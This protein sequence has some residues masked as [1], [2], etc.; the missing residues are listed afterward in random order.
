MLKSLTSPFLALRSLG[1]GRAA[2]ARLSQVVTA[3]AAVALVSQDKLNPYVEARREWNERYSDYIKQAHHWRI[4]ALICAVTA[5]ISVGGVAYIGAQSK[6]VPYV[7]EVD[8]LGAAA[9]VTPADRTTTVDPRVIKAYLARF[10]ADWRAVTVDTQAQKGAIGR[11][12]AMLP[13]GSLALDKLNAFFKAHNPFALA[14]KRSVDVAVTN[15]LP[16]SDK[17]WQ[18]EW[19]EV[20]R[21][22]RG[23]VI[24]N[25]RM[26][27]S[28]IVGITPPTDER[29][30]LINPLGVY[31]TDLN[32]SQQL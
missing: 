32:W 14:A 15:L 2:K 22:S 31:V 1:T 17:T 9:A 26:K 4:V 10:V 7:V 30:I 5:V 11:V 19:R 27:A 8:K 21:D 13:S 12:Y 25:I 28:V 16:I 29:L 24:G 18:L 6:V 20:T 3:T 23:E